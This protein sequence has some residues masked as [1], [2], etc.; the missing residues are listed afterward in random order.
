MNLDIRFPLGLMFGIMGLILAG[1]GLVSGDRAHAGGEAINLNL[2][3]GLLLL[4]FGGIMLFLSRRGV[5]KN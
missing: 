5:Q 4:V 3:W 1:Y 2:W